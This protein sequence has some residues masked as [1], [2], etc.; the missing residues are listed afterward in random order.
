MQSV[1]LRDTI[2]NAD[3]LARRATLFVEAFEADITPAAPLN[4]SLVF[5]HNPSIRLA[6]GYNNMH[7]PVFSESDNRWTEIHLYIPDLVGIPTLVLQGWLDVELAGIVIGQQHTLHRYNFK[8]DILPIFPVSGTAVQFIRYLVAHLENCLKVAMGADMILN[9]QH[10]LPLAYYYY[11]KT[12]PSAEEKQSYRKS[13]PHRWTKAIF[14]CK[15]SK[16][17][18][19]IALLDAGGYLPTLASFWWQCHPYILPED[20]EFMQT[21]A[22]TFL[23]HR[24][25]R[26]A[27]QMVAAFKTVTSGLLT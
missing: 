11:F 27:E 22:T 20:R 12:L 17:F 13:A 10:G 6:E 15:K 18:L 4:V 8:R 1:T 23:A 24:R 19:P 14:V 26:F 9:M 5:H 16:A 3:D 2:L 7:P 21:L 25:D